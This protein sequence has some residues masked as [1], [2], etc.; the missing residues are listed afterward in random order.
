MIDLHRKGARVE[1]I[2]TALGE[3][4]AATRR[5]ADIPG[6]EERSKLTF[7]VTDGN[8]LVGA[9]SNMPLRYSTYKSHCL[10]RDNCPFLSPECEAPTQTGKVNHLIVS[11]EELSGDNIW[12][13]LE[14]DHFIAVDWS[15]NL[16]QGALP[17]S[18]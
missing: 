17:L 18:W 14:E 10:D 2:V 8:A 5:V 3:T 15:M 11:S 16:S 9:R 6:Q 12:H 13:E 4:I 1:D 7:V